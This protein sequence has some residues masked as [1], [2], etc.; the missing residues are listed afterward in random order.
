MLLPHDKSKNGVVI[1][2][3]QIERIENEEMDDTTHRAYK[4]IE[5]ARN[6]IEEKKYYKELVAHKVKNIIKLPIVFV[7]K[8]PF[9]GK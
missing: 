5:E 1:E 2:I 4:K 9:I 3:K 6:Q 7:G 8:E